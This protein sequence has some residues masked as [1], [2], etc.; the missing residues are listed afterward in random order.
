MKGTDNV[1]MEQ[2]LEFDDSGSYGLPGHGLK[3]KVQRSRFRLR[4]RFFSQRVVDTWNR[5]S[6][7][8]VE[9]SSVNVFKKR[10][11]E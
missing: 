6:S 5:L 7:S 4:Q 9:A 3:I 11:D 8:V 10:L 2:F 1:D